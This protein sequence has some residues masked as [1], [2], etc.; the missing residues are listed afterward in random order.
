MSAFRF[1]VS[2]IVSERLFGL[3]NLD[4]RF[5][6]GRR[7]QPFSDGEIRDVKGK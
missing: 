7:L 5:K 4:P 2:V 6:S 3:Q 1:G